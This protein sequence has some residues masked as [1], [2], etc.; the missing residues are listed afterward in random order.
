MMIKKE[1]IKKVAEKKIKE[2]GG[3]FVDI[4][5][6]PAN[7]ITLFFDRIEGVQVHH[8]VEITRHI[9][10][11][12]DREIE[13]YEL[14]VCSAGLDNPFIV[15]EQYHKYNGKEV[16]VLLNNGKREKGIILSYEKE[17]LTLEIKKTKK[18]NVK[19]KI[20]EKLK[21]LKSEIKETKLKINFK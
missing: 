9:E 5:V 14:T 3:F 12:F 8:C 13:D 4:K 1:E 17:I 7:V 6:N 21:I 2:L 10:S 11:I 15:E 19:Q 18:G 20:I 16:K